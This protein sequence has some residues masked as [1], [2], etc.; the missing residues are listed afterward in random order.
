M[1]KKKYRRVDA[2]RHALDL[3]H[4]R[5]QLGKRSRRPVSSLL[6][7]KTADATAYIHSGHPTRSRIPREERG[8][9]RVDAE[10]HGLDLVHGRGQLGKR[11]RRPVAYLPSGDTAEMTV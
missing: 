8:Y 1:K 6:S 10:G 9:R 7:G 2:E 3:V 5:G 4:G 11:S